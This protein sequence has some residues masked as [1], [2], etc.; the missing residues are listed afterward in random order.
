MTPCE[1][2]VWAAL[3]NRAVSGVKFRR[4]HPFEGFILDF[5]AP[6]LRLAIE[7]DGDVHSSAGQQSY[8]RWR[9]NRLAEV[10]VTV[11]RITNEEVAI[12]LPDVVS[13]VRAIIE[14]VRPR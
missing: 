11:V 5:Y 6:E 9:E 3:R 4:Q 1:R 13:R 12:N 10:G 2:T 14:S 8:D 7:I